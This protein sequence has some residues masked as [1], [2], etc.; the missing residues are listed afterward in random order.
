MLLGR[1]AGD[2]TMHLLIAGLALG[3]PPVSPDIPPVSRRYSPR[4]SPVFLKVPPGNP[5]RGL[6]RA[7]GGSNYDVK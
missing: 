1:A 6:H 2:G 4:I 5:P 7:Q 3:T